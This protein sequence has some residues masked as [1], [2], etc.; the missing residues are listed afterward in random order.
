MHVVG[1]KKLEQQG[2]VRRID[3]VTQ[4]PLSERKVGRHSEVTVLVVAD[5]QRVKRGKWV[6][7]QTVAEPLLVVVGQQSS[8]SQFS[9]HHL[10]ISHN[11][12]Y[13]L[14]HLLH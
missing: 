8:L 10:L 3:E 6:V 7:R 9:D 13:I 1:R 4:I 14:R 2:P 5:C 11:P 12:S